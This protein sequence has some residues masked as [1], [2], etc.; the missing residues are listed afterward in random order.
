[1]AKLD[2]S[3]KRKR[4]EEFKKRTPDLGYYYIVTDTQKTEKNY[5]EGLRDSLP[6]DLQ[7]RIVIK[8]EETKTCKL[9]ETCQEQ[10]SLSSQYREVWIVFD[11]DQ[12]INFDEII[13]TA[14]DKGINIAWSNPCIEIWFE[15]YFGKM[16]YYLNSV[17]CCEGF[18]VTFAKKTKQ[19]YKKSDEQIYNLL[20]H[21]G[22]ENKAI[23][24]AEV[25]YK[26][27]IKDGNEK[28]SEMCPCTTVFEL[29]R[30]I[31]SKISQIN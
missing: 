31:K 3:G 12:V 15:A 20:N 28:P 8:V 17:A 14:E 24:I 2:R 10:I 22:D 9:I 4:R 6:E 25:R 26:D 27:H 30:E 7:G 1:M 29:I 5:F 23:E 11:R 18:G 19:G 16:N 13:K 21:Y